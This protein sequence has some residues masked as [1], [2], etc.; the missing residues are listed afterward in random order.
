MRPERVMRLPPRE[1]II[2]AA[3]EL[4]FNEGITRVTVD[5]IAAKAESTKM[6][7]YRHFESKDAL[8]LE[9]IRLHI[10]QYREIFERLA[11]EHPD[12]PRAQLLGFAQFI[13][14]DLSTS[15]YRGCSFTNVIA[16]IADEQHPARVLIE[17]HKQAQFHR[18]EQLCRDAGLPEPSEAAEELT[19]LMEGAQIVSQNRG[20]TEVGDKLLRM[21]RKIIGA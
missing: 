3:Q 13:A 4:F 5:A 17:A 21:V 14:D 7:L 15:S 12:A 19:Y 8:V 10:E 20:I 18:L 9:W 11:A 1:R 2:D 16:E 6:T